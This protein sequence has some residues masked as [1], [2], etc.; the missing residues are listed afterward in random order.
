MFYIIVFLLLALFGLID[1]IKVDKTLKKG[2]F[3]SVL[4]AFIL[5]GGIKWKTGSDWLS[6]SFFFAYYDSWGDFTAG[7]FEIGWGI[8]NYLIKLFTSNYTVFL[9]IDSLLIISLKG[10]VFNKTVEYKL[11]IL[12]VFFSFLIADIFAVRQSLAISI[13]FISVIF[14]IKKSFFPFLLFVFLATAIHNTSIVF[15]FAYWI[16]HAKLSNTALIIFI[17]ISLFIGLSGIL[18]KLLAPLDFVFSAIGG[19]TG[20]RVSSKFQIYTSNAA[21]TDEM[22][23]RG[24]VLLGFIRRSF[25]I[26]IYL[27]LRNYCNK[28]VDKYDGFL[29]LFVFGNVMYFIFASSLIIFVRAA[30]FYMIFEMFLLVYILESIKSHKIRITVYFCMVIYC[31]LKLYI[32]LTSYWDLY[33]PFNTIFD[34]N[35]DRILY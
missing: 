11:V 18:V 35:I 9:L 31:A 32:N 1:F 33:V 25:L 26:P 13:C 8:W 12:L 5:L 19:S 16:F 34:S 3:V 29:K 7:L 4:I 2:L 15:I 30:V 21:N 10:Y 23:S 28:R 17:A 14:I 24:M 20:E 6:Y 27:L 22:G